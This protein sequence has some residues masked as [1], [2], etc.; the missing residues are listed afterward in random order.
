MKDLWKYRW[1]AYIIFWITY[2][3]MILG[4]FISDV[5]FF[6]G[7]GGLTIMV[8]IF[9]IISYSHES[10]KRMLDMQKITR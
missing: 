10:Q 4:S 5:I 7:L 3:V 9:L 8:I 1:K 6:L 2:A